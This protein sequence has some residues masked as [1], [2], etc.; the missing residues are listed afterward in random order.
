MA[1]SFPQAAEI[2]WQVARNL[3]GKISAG[4]LGELV[5]TLEGDWD[6]EELTI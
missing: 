3:V 4:I 6:M 1:P 5:A 2:P